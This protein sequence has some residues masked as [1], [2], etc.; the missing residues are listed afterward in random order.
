[1]I[2]KLG[3]LFQLDSHPKVTHSSPCSS[4]NANFLL[5]LDLTWT[6]GGAS[7]VF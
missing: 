2:L 3:N 1:M 4:T 7:I 6:M 5:R